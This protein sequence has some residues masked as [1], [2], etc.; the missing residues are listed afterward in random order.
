[1]VEAD[2]TIHVTRGDIVFL[3]VS[4]MDEDR[5]HKFQ[6]NDVVKINVFGKKK[7]GDIVLEESVTVEKET[8]TVEIFISGEKTKIGDVINKHKDYWYEIVLNPETNPRTI[9]GYDDEGAKIFR[10]YPEGDV[11]N[12]ITPG[13]PEDL[14][15]KSIV[16]DIDVFVGKSAYEVAVSNGF[17][18]TEA[19]WLGSLKGEQGE[20]GVSGV[21]LGSGEMPEGYNVQIDPNGQAMFKIVT[22]IATDCNTNE[23]YSASAFNE[24]IETLAGMLADFERRI[25]ALEGK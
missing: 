3:E 5:K 22:E 7:C 16:G 12:D 8:E 4:A 23:I 24:F 14:A 17:E 11:D 19:E 25:S 21:Y 6:P 1:M 15:P 18:G 13:S 2:K 10:L 9:V 20:Q